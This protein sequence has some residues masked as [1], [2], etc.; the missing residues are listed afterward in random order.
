MVSI[1]D[2]R[3]YNDVRTSELSYQWPSCDLKYSFWP[4]EQSHNNLVMYVFMGETNE[5]AQIR[6]AEISWTDG[7]TN[8][9]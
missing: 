7:G 5:A 9:E 3:A 1:G 2:K 8:E 6:I 4:E